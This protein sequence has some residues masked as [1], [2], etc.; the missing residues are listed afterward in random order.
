M[1]QA[2][3]TGAS[4]EAVAGWKEPAMFGYSYGWSPV[5]YEG[6]SLAAIT[7]RVLAGT[8]VDVAGQHTEPVE[9]RT[10]VVRCHP[11]QVLLEAAEGAQMLVLGSGGHG[12]FAGLLLGSVSSALRATRALPGRGRGRVAECHSVRVSRSRA[13]PW[14]RSR[15]GRPRGVPHDPVPAPRGHRITSRRRSPR[16]GPGRRGDGRRTPGAGRPVP[17][18]A[19]LGRRPVSARGSRCSTSSAPRH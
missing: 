15:F 17:R 9:I 5:G 13:G 12:T 7:E 4:M 8:V 6:D 18:P 3:L 10:R 11:A 16:P 1:A 14:Q 19:H 2:R